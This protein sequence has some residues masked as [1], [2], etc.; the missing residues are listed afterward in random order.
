MITTF[1]K[2]CEK[3]KGEITGFSSL[4]RTADLNALAVT[5]KVTWVFETLADRKLA[6]VDA[7]ARIFEPTAI[8]LNETSIDLN[9][10]GRKFSLDSE[11]ECQRIHGG[12]W[13]SVWLKV[14][15]DG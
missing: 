8:A 4:T 10:S 1:T 13:Q 14:I 12:S 11:E 15:D 6:Q 9:F 3:A 7:K 5:L 2:A